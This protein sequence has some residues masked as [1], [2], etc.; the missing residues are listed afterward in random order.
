MIK[1]V[2]NFLDKDIS[3]LHK[4]AYILG[5]SAFL[6]QLLALLRDRIL[7]HTFGAGQSLDIYYT[8]FRIPDFIFI[9]VASIV[10]ISV[11]IPILAKEKDQKKSKE[12]MNEVF[13]VFFF[14]IFFV[15]L[16]AFFLMPKI[17]AL[18][19]RGFS[20]EVLEQVTL[21]SRIMLLSPVLLG[22]SNFFTSI[23]QSQRKFFVYALSPLLYNI[24]IIL[25]VLFYYP[26]WGLKGLALGVVSGAFLHLIIQL[27]TIYRLGFKP[28]FVSKIN[29]YKI[30][31]IFYLS[32]PRTIA[33]SASA[34]SILALISLATY[35]REGSVAIFNFAYAIQSIPLSIIGVSYTT[36]VF[37]LLSKIEKEKKSEF[38]DYLNLTARYI[39]FWT[40]LA[41]ILLFFLRAQVV[42]T[43]LGSG[44]FSWLDTRLTAACLALFAI[45]VPA[46]SLILF[47]VRVY[48]AANLTKRPVFI[49]FISFTL[50]ILFVF[51]FKYLFSIFP[52][53]L[54]YLA[55]FLRVED[56]NDV[57]VLLLPL[58]FS[59]AT[60]INLT[61]FY[62]FIKKD[63][64]YKFCGKFYFILQICVALLLTSLTIYFSLKIWDNIF[65]VKTLFG[66]FFQGLFS[67]ISGILIWFISLVLLKNTEVLSMLSFIKKFFRL[68]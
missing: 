5:F 9:T 62:F 68:K 26:L 45:S 22:L 18:L 40:F 32:L 11:L 27:P 56:I 14:L 65:D 13:S 34:L 7:A 38:L 33:V 29:F 54:N 52:A 6:S 41:A 8:A 46:Q 61:L 42:R 10:S 2:F 36:A 43:V 12:T 50:V 15:V 37:P 39:L 21:L 55:S 20:A 57:Q 30:K 44:E 59:C 24:G 66:I 28:S 19:F 16:V 3:G 4:A 63:F 25:G 35:L 31:N 23:I 67:G 1:K 60:L 58:A 49:N 64:S 17:N 47:F 51:L 48:Y 53:F